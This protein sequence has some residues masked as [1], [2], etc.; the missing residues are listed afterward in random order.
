MSYVRPSKKRKVFP[1]AG[2]S[3]KIF[4]LAVMD[5]SKERNEQY[6]NLIVITFIFVLT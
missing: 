4:Y 3:K 1:R 6:K 5:A 2:S